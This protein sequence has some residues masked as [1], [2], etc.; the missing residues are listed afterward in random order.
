[1]TSEGKKSMG[2]QGIY[3]IMAL[4]K[5]ELGIFQTGVKEP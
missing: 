3:P 1:M 4:L 2:F 5:D